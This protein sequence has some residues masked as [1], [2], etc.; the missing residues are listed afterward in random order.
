MISN[1]RA[2]PI[3]GFVTDSAG[4]VI[5]NAS[6]SIARNDPSG[7]V[8]VA[9]A[10]SDDEGYFVSDP[11]PNGTYDILESGVITSRIIHT[12]DRVSIPC[13]RAPKDNYY[14]SDTYPFSDLVASENLNGYKY[15]LQI[16]P[17]NISVDLLGS[18]FPIHEKS[19]SGLLD[20][21]SDI[22]Y[23]SKFF[24]FTSDARITIPRFD[25]EYF[26]PLTALQLAYRRIKWAG[27]PGIR[28]KPDSKIVVPLDYYSIVANNPFIVSNNGGSFTP[29]DVTVSVVGAKKITISGSVQEYIT[30][31]NSVGIGDILRITY[32]VE[33]WYGIVLRK[34]I[35][36]GEYSIA[37]EQWKSSRFTG[38][39]PSSI[40]ISI[41]TIKA[42]HG[43]FQGMTSLSSTVSD[44]FTVAENLYQQT[45]PDEL[46]TYEN[47]NA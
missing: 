20:D 6:I 14:D 32:G 1:L 39:I 44:Y 23:M 2:R 47:W 17:E 3:Q 10:T 5:R 28:Y 19:L 45:V 12:P 8:T 21:G 43:I 29:G 11:L 22:Y 4:N 35:S 9:L 38:T 25:I 36:A 37:L 16:E 42:Y 27:V 15:F 33:E 31:Y 34:E 7:S 41:L 40:G 30:I 24:A 13:F 18:S 46:Y 26:Q